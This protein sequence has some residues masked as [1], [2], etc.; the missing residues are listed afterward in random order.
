M[1]SWNWITSV[2][3]LG[4]Q[5]SPNE[6]SA[7]RSQG[8]TD[9]LDLRGEPRQSEQ[10]TQ[11][12]YAGTGIAY[13]YLPMLDRGG[14]EPPEKYQAGVAII[15]R[16]LCK[17]NAKVLVHC[18]A[19]RSRSPSMVYAYLRST[20][21]SPDEAWTKIVTSRPV[22]L[23]QYVDYA[24]RAVPSIQHAQCPTNVLGTGLIIGGIVLAGAA[25]IY[26]H[27]R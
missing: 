3:A 26:S 27:A 1:A 22:A 24:E 17:P 14:V 8:I 21:M 12:W 23:R 13:H 15:D 16:A 10:P 6:I 2:I 11:E 18:A 9:V 19:G 25:Y 7:M 20:G 5:P 4:P